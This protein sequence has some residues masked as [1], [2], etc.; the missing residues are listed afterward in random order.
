MSYTPA[1]T[2]GRRKQRVS[3][4][5]LPSRAEYLDTNFPP[6]LVF[7]FSILVLLGLVGISHVVLGE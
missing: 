7:V 2:P 4:F 3:R 5:D 1:L 6:C